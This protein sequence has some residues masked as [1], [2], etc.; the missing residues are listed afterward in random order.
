MFRPPLL[1]SVSSFIVA[2]R[3]HQGQMSH[4]SFKDRHEASRNIHHQDQGLLAVGVA[5]DDRN[6]ERQTESR[7][8]YL[9]TWAMELVP[10]EAAECLPYAVMPYFPQSTAMELP[11][12]YVEAHTSITSRR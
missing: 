1:C 3:S 5:A 12:I 9:T 8:E 11:G 7:A 6:K 10:W 4:V 2:R